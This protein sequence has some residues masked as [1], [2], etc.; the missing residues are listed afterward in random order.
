MKSP[1]QRTTATREG[2]ERKGAL[3]IGPFELEGDSYLYALAGAF[4]SLV[5]WMMLQRA[6]MPWLLRIACAGIPL[7]VSIVWLRVMVIG[8]PPAFQ[9]DVWETLVE[10]RD[11][12][13]AP[14][15]FE[16]WVHPL[17]LPRS[18]AQRRRGGGH[19]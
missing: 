5:A 1:V 9:Q 6:G 10:G 12:W 18:E 13:V 8:R 3:R 11:F 14:R 17:W 4:V 2:L 7:A 15:R 16:R 19:P